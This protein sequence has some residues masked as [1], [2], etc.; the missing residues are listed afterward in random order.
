MKHQRQTSPPYPRPR[1]CLCCRASSPLDLRPTA[2]TVK[3]V[4]H[5]ARICVR[6]TIGA[7]RGATIHLMP[8]ALNRLPRTQKCHRRSHLHTPDR[9]RAGVIRMIK[10]RP[11]LVV[12]VTTAWKT[13]ARLPGCR[14][15][16]P[17]RA[18]NT[19]CAGADSSTPWR[20]WLSRRPK[21]SKPS[22]KSTKTGAKRRP[23]ALRA[24]ALASYS[25]CCCFVRASTR[26][27]S[28]S[29]RDLSGGKAML[30]TRCVSGATNTQRT[31]PTG[32]ANL[33][34][35]AVSAALRTASHL[36][37]DSPP[38]N[39]VAPCL[40]HGALSRVLP[41]Y[42]GRQSG[43]VT[44]KQLRPASITSQ[45]ASPPWRRAIRRTSAKP[46]PVPVQT[47]R[48]LSGDRKAGTRFQIPPGVRLWTIVPDGDDRRLG[49]ARGLHVVGGVP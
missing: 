3:V 21:A 24:A 8:T 35:G 46:N 6:S 29:L 9:L 11:L 13:T 26:Q 23:P 34:T 19:R 30:C 22:P 17:E 39:A 7:R 1:Q 41:E 47:C 18:H 14:E 40:A 44:T 5:Y 27:S 48:R 31:R 45:R 15:G 12:Y 10:R 33:L 25:C 28:I 37:T 38:G 32:N 36:S 4:S 43:K 20:A 2:S 16:G 42:R 49:A